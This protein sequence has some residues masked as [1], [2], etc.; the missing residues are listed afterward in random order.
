MRANAGRIGRFAG[1]CL[2]AGALAACGDARQAATAP[3]TASAIAGLD[4]HVVPAADASAGRAWEGVIEAVRQAT[5]SA[6]THGRV[7]EVR[8]D[9]DDRVAAGDLLVRLSAIEQQ[10]AVDSAR[11]QLHA[12]EAVVA[13]ADA[14]WRR[15]RELSQ[16]HHVSMAQLDQ[17]RM[18]RDSAIA[19]RDAAR[20][21]LAESDQQIAYTTIRAPYAGIVGSRDVEPGES[22]VT[23]QPLVTVFS[24][25]ALRIELSIPQSD[26]E[27]LLAQPLAHI[28]FADA[29]SVEA[30]DVT[31]FPSADPGTHAVRVRVQL[32]QLDP[33]PRP[34]TTAKVAFP[35]LAG[36]AYPYVPVSALV[37]R[38]EINAVYVLVDGRLSLRQLRLGQ[39]TGEDVQV[40][41]GLRPGE[42]IAADPIG[43]AQALVA[44]RAAP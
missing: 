17:S 33:A 3:A 43:A 39:R 40:I 10:A 32:P 11:A 4:T 31:V 16:R 20:A 21:R 41:S 25:D 8:Y 9:V 6:Q 34:G 37:R 35:A 36:A 24:P 1:A 42:T 15:H 5:L 29:R 44:A 19:A 12:A 22:V 28:T 38:G 26:A 2:L 13:E 30:T 23:N 7:A 14:T 27:R 18:M